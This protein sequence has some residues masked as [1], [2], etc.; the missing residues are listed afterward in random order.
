M[1][2]RSFVMSGLT[3]LSATRVIG[4]NDRVRL[5]IIGTGGRGRLLMRQANKEPNIQWVALCD[6][7]DERCYQGAELADESAK[8]YRDYRKLLDHTDID[9]VIVATWDN[10][11][12]WLT[13]KVCESGK[14]AYV[15][16][17]M[18]NLPEEGLPLV[19]T[20]KKTNRIVQV[21]M[22]QRSIEGFV[23]AK[24]KIIDTGMLGKIHMVRTL[25]NGNGGYLAKVP[26]GMEQKPKD[27]DWEACL[28]KLPKK[29]WDPKMYFNRFSY[30]DLSCGGMSGG[31]FVHLVDVVHW[32]LNLEKAKSA[33]AL[34]G[35]YHHK[36]GRTIPDTINFIV[37][38]PQDINVT[39]EASVDGLGKA[40]I[41]FIGDLGELSIFRGGYTYTPTK[42]NTDAAEIKG[43][44]GNDLHMHNWV[45][46]IQTRKQPNADAIQGHYSSMACH[47]GNIA[48]QEKRRVNWRKE[49]DV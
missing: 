13:Q 30:W 35:I 36:D 18:T 23:E 34:G 5:G 46:C 37:D 31:L 43:S 48:Y 14:D 49:W 11:H 25:W 42:Q 17:P 1:N 44:G 20:V 15:E 45:D 40:D 39:F 27:L 3:A 32:Y 16:K 29:P 22:Q 24:E 8:Q 38:Y 9:G 28:G 12:A 2:R 4:A 6:A 21:G 33:V 19:R 10:N 7:W 26:K 41:V 47:I